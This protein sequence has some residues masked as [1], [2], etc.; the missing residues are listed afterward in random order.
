MLTGSSIFSRFDRGIVPGLT[1]GGVWFAGLTLGLWAARFYGGPLGALVPAAVG[2]ELTFWNACMTAVL[3]LFLLFILF[4]QLFYVIVNNF[5]LRW[6][7]LFI[8]PF[9]QTTLSY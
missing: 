9:F 5:A 7:I 4:L 2:S 3:P 8:V 6:R 1:L